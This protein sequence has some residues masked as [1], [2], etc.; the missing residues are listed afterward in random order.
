MNYGKTIIL[1]AVSALTA[2]VVFDVLGAPTAGGAADL[3]LEYTDK[4]HLA[5]S[6]ELSQH[7]YLEEMSI[8]E[9]LNKAMLKLKDDPSKSENEFRRNFVKF[10]TYK[11]SFFEPAFKAHGVSIRT[12]DDV[13]VSGAMVVTDEM[14]K[15]MSQV[16]NQFVAYKMR[17]SLR[18]EQEKAIDSLLRHNFCRDFKVALDTAQMLKDGEEYFSKRFAQLDRAASKFS[19]RDVHHIGGAVDDILRSEKHGSDYRKRVVEAMG[20]SG[21]IQPTKPF[22]LGPKFENN[23]KALDKWLK[24]VSD[25]RFSAWESHLEKVKSQSQK[26]TKAMDSSDKDIWQKHLVSAGV[27]SKSEQEYVSK[28]HMN[29]KQM[30][31]R[32][33]FIVKRMRELMDK[34]KDDGYVKKLRTGDGVLPNFWNKMGGGRPTEGD[35]GYYPH[36]KKYVDTLESRIAGRE[37]WDAR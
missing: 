2:A 20:L 37:R 34:L 18:L 8:S 21:I 12:Y 17:Y 25:S 31:D 16:I 29:D 30:C 13:H 4:G 1:F 28:I 36:I 26:L 23:L 24:N 9:C 32:L 27:K 3:G 7:I 11:Q 15:G 22:R 6:P 33:E 5:I 14:Q 19:L 35:N 10:S